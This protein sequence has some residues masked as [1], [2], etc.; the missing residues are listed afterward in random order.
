MPLFNHGAPEATAAIYEVATRAVLSGEY[1][2]PR[3]AQRALERGLRDGGRNHDMS[4]RAWTY[5]RAMDRA[6]NE[7]EGRLAMRDRH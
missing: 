1:E 6:L 3:R 4:D 5:R 2:L 7:I